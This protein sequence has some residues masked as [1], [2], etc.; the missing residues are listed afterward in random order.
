[1]RNP[2]P[3][4]SSMVTLA[5]TLGTTTPV[6]PLLRKA[7]RMGIRTI[8]EMIALAVSR[9][10]HHYPAV[11]SPSEIP[12][13][14]SGI[15]DEELTILL[16][17]G[18]NTYDPNAIRCAAQLARSPANRP[19]R[20]AK[21]AI[22]ENCQRVLSHIARA[23]VEHDPEEPDFWKQLLFHLSSPAPRKEPALPHW[24]RFVS[25]PG[26]QRHGPAPSRWLVPRP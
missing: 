11:L 8:G 6:S 12:S 20:L 10:C 13:A 23:G 24:S 9:G 19:E 7:R 22:M 1:M 2:Q 4:I 26:L 5:Q 16:I 21:L 18:E 3:V 25:M 14:A 17:L 15:S